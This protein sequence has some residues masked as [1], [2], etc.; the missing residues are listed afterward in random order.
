MS[1]DTDSLRK[2]VQFDYLLHIAGMIF[3]FGILT[4]VA[5][6]LN[7]LKRDSAAGTVYESHMNYMIRYWWRWVLWMLVVTVIYFLLGLITLSIGF[8][9]FAWLFVVP[10]IIFVYRMVMGLLAANDGRPAPG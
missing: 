9:I 4:L 3:S 8:F 10:S 1:S 7:Y 6:V 5:I 2:V